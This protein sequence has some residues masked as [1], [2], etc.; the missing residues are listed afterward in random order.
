MR[1][2]WWTCSIAVPQGP[3]HR[4]TLGDSYVDLQSSSM[5][6]SHI[7]LR[8]SFADL[9]VHYNPGTMTDDPR[10]SVHVR[11]II[12]LKNKKFMDNLANAF[13]T[14]QNSQIR[15]KKYVF[16]P[17]SKIV[18][19]ICTILYVEGFIRGLKRIDISDSIDREE[20]PV[21][22]SVAQ[23]YGQVHDGQ[24]N[25]H[26]MPYPCRL[27][28]KSVTPFS[29][30]IIYLKYLNNKPII[31]KISK[32]SLQGRRIYTKKMTVDSLHRGDSFTTASLI[33]QISP[34]LC[35]LTATLSGTEDMLGD[36]TK[37]PV[38]DSLTMP[39]ATLSLTRNMNLPSLSKSNLIQN[40]EV[41]IPVT[42]G[43]G[44]K[45]L[46]TSKGILCDRDA[47]FLGVGGEI[48]CEIL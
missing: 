26:P 40:S 19:N 9:Q 8:N 23:K 34:Q 20:S 24:H 31:E 41:A 21:S 29:Y 42:Q 36:H 30:I 6:W 15:R 12:H 46:S 37:N 22:V 43:F 3:C 18:W 14:L 28:K 10:S 44:L 11:H 17:F 13:S 27:K 2:I 32:I 39:S 45:I 48:L 47:R 33:M 25:C 16:I 4:R 38:I 5:S 35:G 1:S 7:D